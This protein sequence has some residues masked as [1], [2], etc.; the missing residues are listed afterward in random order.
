MIFK[1]SMRRF[2]IYHDVIKTKKMQSNITQI[3]K[4]HADNLFYE[5]AQNQLIVLKQF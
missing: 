1:V 3:K 2:E 5:K 4:D